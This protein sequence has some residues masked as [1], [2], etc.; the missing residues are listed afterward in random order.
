VRAAKKSCGMWCFQSFGAAGVDFRSWT[1][2]GG[3]L[4]KLRCLRRTFSVDN[5]K[6]FGKSEK[7]S[8]VAR[9]HANPR[10]NFDHFAMESPAS[11]FDHF[12][13]AASCAAGGA[14]PPFARCTAGGAARRSQLVKRK[15]RLRP[16]KPQL[17]LLFDKMYESTGGG[18]P[19][20]ATKNCSTH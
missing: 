17:F 19:T 7:R 18:S 12:E 10:G 4:S 15:E 9:G 5:V 1:R 3:Q 11:H 13:I 16:R 2:N 6:N 14:W 20:L 8:S